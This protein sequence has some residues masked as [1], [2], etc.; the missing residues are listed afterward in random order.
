MILTE[1]EQKAIQ[2]MSVEKIIWKDV[3]GYE[4]F[5]KINNFGDI[6]SLN[7][8]SKGTRNRI[9]YRKGRILK[10]YKAGKGYL[11]VKLHNKSYFVHR[12]IAIVFI[13]KKS[14]YKEINHKNG[15]KTD[16]RIE[17]LE[18]C[19]RSYNM[20]HAVINGLVTLPDNKGEKCAKSK[21][22]NNDV[23]QIRNKYATG[24]YTQK[25]LASIYNISRVNISK[26]INYKIWKNI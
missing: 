22:K 13:K 1:K 16:N 19:T 26:I 15:I 2:N 6:K 8:I 18:W 4:G 24:L 21:L 12:L 23:L 25:E 17:N 9:N 14:N 20:K 5:Y 3:P 11:Q 7:I 10:P